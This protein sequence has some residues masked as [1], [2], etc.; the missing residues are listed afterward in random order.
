MFNKLAEK[1]FNQLEAVEEVD[2]ISGASA[3]RVFISAFSIDEEFT[4]QVWGFPGP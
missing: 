3:N 1:Y 4:D 2:F